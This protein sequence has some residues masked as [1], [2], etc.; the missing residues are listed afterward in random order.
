MVLLLSA[1]N[2]AEKSQTLGNLSINKGRG[3]GREGLQDT[4]T[5]GMA[6]EVKLE[7]CS[8]KGPGNWLAPSSRHHWPKGG[9]LDVWG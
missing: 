4:D 1:R 8:I 5:G 7:V 3:G 9:E 2:L 6:L